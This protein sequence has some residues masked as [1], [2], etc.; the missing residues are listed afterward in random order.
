MQKETVILLGGEN[1][2]RDEMI[3]L[4]I[5]DRINEWV[6]ARMHEG[7]EEVLFSGWKGYDEYTDEELDEA[8]ELLVEEN[9]T[10][11]KAEKIKFHKLQIER[12]RYIN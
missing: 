4:L 3:E 8:F 1:M 7:L 2:T 6:H 10:P 9:F 11:D 5:E 12:K